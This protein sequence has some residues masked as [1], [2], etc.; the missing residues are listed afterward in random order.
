M[1]KKYRAELTLGLMVILTIVGG[2]S[3]HLYYLSITPANKVFSLIHNHTQDYFYYLHFM[4]QGLNGAWRLTSKFTPESFEPQLIQTFFAI[5][6]KVARIFSGDLALTYFLARLVLGIALAAAI[7][8]LAS[9]VLKEK[10]L[11]LLAGFLAFFSTGFWYPS[12]F[13]HKWVI[14]RS[15][16][17]WTEFDTL[18]RATFLPHHLAANIGVIASIILLVSSLNSKKWPS[19]ILAG[20]A[21]FLTGFI[22]PV[23]LINLLLSLAVASLVYLASWTVVTIKHPGSTRASL[24]PLFHFAFCLLIF[25]L[26]S[27]LSLVHLYLIQQSNF[28]WTAYQTHLATLRFNLSVT[29][30]LLGMGPS[31][32]FASMAFLPFFTNYLQSLTLPTTLSKVYIPN[33]RSYYSL[34]LIGWS[35]GPLVGIFI[36]SR[37]F[38]F[39]PNSYFFQA[40]HYIPLTILG[41][42]GLEKIL[43]GLQ[44]LNRL[45]PY[46]FLTILMAYF[47]VSWYESYRSETERFHPY[48][49][50]IFIDNELM[51]GFNWL[52]RESGK[53]DPVVM[54]GR[55][56]GLIL[57]AYAK[58]RVHNG[59]VPGNF[60]ASAK[61]Q[62][63]ELFYSQK[64]VEASRKIINKYPIDYIFYG[65]ETP[66]PDPDFIR[67]LDLKLAY[68]NS[69]IWIY[70][71]REQRF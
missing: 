68:Q 11:Q 23:A 71:T 17:F 8:I 25:V 48:L 69:L 24:K 7:I 59:Y 9:K 28:P 46:I 45:V 55:Y 61:Q 1:F 65:L 57:P 38:P 43:S 40:A 18:Q 64:D 12:V 52:N 62:E 3:P 5:L 56:L 22:N 60:E 66:P 4:R 26:V 51:E 54:T 21:G 19:L 67:K 50:N 32:V 63:R 36:V 29:D 37:Y 58:V 6:G 70:K 16:T 30:Y 33:S 13:N 49:F 15:L 47:S 20:V 14:Q 39:L 44:R 10:K 2:I 27:S 34:F 42:V 53:S 35:L 31:L 41:A